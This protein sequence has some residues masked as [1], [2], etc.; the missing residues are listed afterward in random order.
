[1]SSSRKRS[2]PLLVVL[3]APSGAGKTTLATQILA[4]RKDM[5]RSVSCTTRHPRGAEVDGRDYYF[6]SREAF[7]Q[8]VSNGDFL[9][10]A[11]VHGNHYGTLRKTV[12]DALVA[13]R[14]VLL[15]ID[16]QGAGLVRDQARRMPEESPIHRGFVDIFVMPP[17]RAVLKERLERRGED[18][19]ETIRQRLKNAEKEMTRA[20]DFKYAIVND[21]LN[22]AVEQLEAILDNEAQATI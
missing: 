13:R 22:A 20:N 8:R 18:D 14:S 16:V 10:H 19:T 2:R 11:V 17:S 9:E 4:K 21:E 7:N 15:V 6:L 12:E 5:I 1:M 3:S